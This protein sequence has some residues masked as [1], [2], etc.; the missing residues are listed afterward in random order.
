VL[1][2]GGAERVDHQLGEALLDRREVLLVVL[3]AVV[4]VVAALE[5]DLGAAQFDR[6]GAAAQ[7]V[8]KVA[9]PDVVALRRGVEGAELAGRDAGVG[10]VDVPLDDVRR[11]VLRARVALAP[12]GVR[13]RAEGVQRC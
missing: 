9:R 3:H 13:R 11:D 6:L 5:H 12:C 8:V 4:R 7:D 10:V 1:D 2:L